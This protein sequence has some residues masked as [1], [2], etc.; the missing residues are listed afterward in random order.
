MISSTLR[1]LHQYPYFATLYLVVGGGFF[2]GGGKPPI[3]F[4]CLLQFTFKKG[5]DGSR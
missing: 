1:M 3:H 4:H 5:V 2:F